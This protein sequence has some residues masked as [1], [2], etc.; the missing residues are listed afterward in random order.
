MEGMRERGG[1]RGEKVRGGK[2]AAGEKK[3]YRS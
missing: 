2:K 3:L 1:R